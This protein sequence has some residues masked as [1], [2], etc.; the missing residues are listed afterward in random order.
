MTTTKEEL[1]ESQIKHID[2]LTYKTFINKFNSTYKD[3]LKEEQKKLLTNFIVSFSDN[4][5]GLKSFL[6][7]EIGRL[8]TELNQ[9]IQNGKLPAHLTERSKKVVDR[10][11]NFAKTPITEQMVQD[12]FYIQDLVGEISKNG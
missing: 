12:V 4:G 6:N 11:D 10:L 8:K 2:K 5:L 3:T 9:T 7:E 1:S